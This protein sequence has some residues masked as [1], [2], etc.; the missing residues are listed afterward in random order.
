MQQY[1]DTLTR[2]LN[3]GQK[4][5]DRTGTGTLSCFGHQ[6]RFNIAR[7]GF[8]LLTTKKLHFKSIVHEL[9]WFMKGTT[10]TKYLKE[11]GVTIW[12]EWEDK[13]GNIG[14]MYG[15]LM[16]SWPGREQSH[17]QIQTVINDL[18]SNPGSRRH[19]VTQWNPD[20]LDKQ[21][22]A[23]CHVLQQY[24]SYEATFQQRLE[25]YNYLDGTSFTIDEEDI[26][27]VK[28]FEKYFELSNIPKRI[29]NLQ[30][31]Q[32]KMQCALA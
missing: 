20:S 23:C 11:N 27:T 2:I 14:E 8:P 12:D 28:Q 24:K 6:M 22:L 13:E 4:E 21:A 3:E 9:L 26:D 25:W 5:M 29:L 10:D 30:M 15:F 1:L 19:L 7:D 16:R 17:D 18:K 32:R 31:T